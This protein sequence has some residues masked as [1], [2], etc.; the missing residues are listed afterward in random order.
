MEMNPMQVRAAEYLGDVGKDMLRTRRKGEE[1]SLYWGVLCRT[2]RELVAFDEC[3]YVSFGPGAIGMRPGAIQCAEGHNHTYFPLD[4]RFVPFGG[5]IPAETMERNRE[6][7]K[8]ANQTPQAWSSRSEIG[9]GWS[10]SWAGR[11]FHR[12]PRRA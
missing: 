10:A 2:C 5:R 4:F 7:F 11:E 8:A 12:E 1:S 9:L 6:A 3:P